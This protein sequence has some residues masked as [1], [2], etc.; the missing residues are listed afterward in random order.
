VDEGPE[1]N[2]GLNL[3]DY[4][5]ARVLLHNQAY[6]VKTFMN[7]EYHE[8]TAEGLSVT[9]A[10]GVKKTL[11]ADSIIVALP[12]SVDTSLAEKLKEKVDEVY[13]IGDCNKTGVIVDA[14][15]AGNLTARK[16]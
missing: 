10:Y 8:I 7:V 3:P 6:G 16:I 14:V 9:T 13:A 11:K 4:V 15:E 2:L 12:M 5:K 1:E